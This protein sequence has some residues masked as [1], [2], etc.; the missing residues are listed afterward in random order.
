MAKQTLGKAHPIA[1]DGKTIDGGTVIT[2]KT[3]VTADDSWTALTCPVAC[4]SMYCKL[5]SGNSFKMSHQSAGTLYMTEASFSA[6]VA[7][8]A[9]DTLFYVQNSSGADVLEVAYLD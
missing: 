8:R 4:K 5:R 6:N 7:A 9:D 3:F 1:S 2:I